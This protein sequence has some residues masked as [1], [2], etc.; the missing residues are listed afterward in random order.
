MIDL[1]LEGSP[2][3]WQTVDAPSGIPLLIAS[4][5]GLMTSEYMD[6]VETLE[7]HLPE[8]RSFVFVDPDTE[9]EVTTLTIGCVGKTLT[10]QADDA[11]GVEVSAEQGR[12]LHV[13]SIEDLISGPEPM[14]D[15]V[16]TRTGKGKYYASRTAGDFTLPLHEIDM[17]WRIADVIAAAFLSLQT[18]LATGKW[19]ESPRA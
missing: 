4:R 16:F 8:S 13:I 9:I 7:W 17:N 1:A 18:R 11:G 3:N 15:F 12:F 2:Y 6:A 14:T 19:P 5:V 10:L